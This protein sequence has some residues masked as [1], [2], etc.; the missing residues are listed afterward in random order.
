MILDI[1]TFSILCDILSVDTFQYDWLNE[2]TTM[3]YSEGE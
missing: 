1:I 2:W 3:I